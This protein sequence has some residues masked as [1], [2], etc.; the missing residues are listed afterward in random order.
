MCL[1]T[2][3]LVRKCPAD[4]LTIFIPDSSQVS[5]RPFLP[6]AE[7]VMAINLLILIWNHFGH[8]IGVDPCAVLVMH[9]TMIG[10]LIHS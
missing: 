9:H 10:G 1:T 4:K 8:A 5:T 3:A 6:S 2:A 7:L